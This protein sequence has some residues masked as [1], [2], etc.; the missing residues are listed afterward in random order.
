[1]KLV[2]AEK[3]IAAKRIA[4]ILG[5][6]KS[7]LKAGVECYQLEDSIVVPLKGHIMDVDFPK[8]YANWGQ[9]DLFALTVAPLLYE[10]TQQSIVKALESFAPQCSELIISTDYDR[11]GE[12]IGKE[13]VL[14]IQKKNPTIK[15]KRVKFSALTPQEVKSAFSKPVEFDWSLAD[16]ADA[17]REIDLIWGAVLTRYVSLTS[18]RLGREFLSV[19][20]VQSPVLA[21]IVDLEKEILAFKPEPFW[22]ISILCDKDGEKFT[23]TYH[24]ERIFNKVRAVALSALKFKDAEVKAVEK[25]QM[26]L[27]PPTPFNTTEFLRA[28]SLVGIQP[29]AAMSIAEKLYME[30]FTSYPRTDNTVYPESLDLKEILQKLG[31]SKEFG[32]LAD[33]IL[34]QKKLKPTQGPKKATDHPPIH[35][36]EVADKAK[37]S[38]QEWKVYALIV[39]RFLATFA[40]SCFLDTVK[41]TLDHGGEKFVARGKTI[42]E[43]GWREFYPYSK[44]NE[45]EL[46]ELAEKEK[47]GVDK[48]DLKNDE[49][50]PKPRYTPAALIKLMENL[51]LGTKA[52]RA[53]ILQK[54]L[55]RGYVSGKQNLTPSPIA[56]SVIDALEKY[57]LDIAKPDMT[58]ALEQ[59][60]NLV[61]QG[62]KAKDDV[63]A[64]SRA[65]LNKVL[66]ELVSHQDQIAKTLQEALMAESIVGKCL[67]CGGNLRIIQTNRGT[68]FIG[69]SGYPKGCRVSFPLPAK[70]GIKVTG[71]MCEHC[72]LPII[73][74]RFFKKRPFEMCINHKCPSKA[75]WGKKK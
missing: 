40:P 66:K 53:E 8:K 69:C 50:K 30:G 19:G 67:S 73:E 57:A 64:E 49:T 41:V 3:P 43:K 4:S 12:S 62:K 46:P 14:A 18:R 68:R 75:N 13:A 58:A 55:Y 61:E 38:L 21:L 48:L 25:K 15:V 32:K 34:K 74:V 11:E 36:V 29:A 72:K 45:V 56:F 10:P 9:T 26:E 16:S 17:R 7:V 22:V 47:V 5:S 60:M 24:E 28:A 31:K 33:K 71:K 51:N 52:T 27:K 2:V 59:E 39:H 63:V 23:A 20:R 54:L 42:A 1:M 6:P 44:T 65:M 70:G 37:L 35:P